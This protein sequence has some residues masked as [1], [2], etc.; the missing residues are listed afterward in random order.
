MNRRASRWAARRRATRRRRVAVALVVLASCAAAAAG[1]W[2]YGDTVPA[3]CRIDDLPEHPCNARQLLRPDGTPFDPTLAGG[4]VTG[5]DIIEWYGPD[6]V[7]PGPHTLTVRD[8][9]TGETDS[10]P[11]T[12]I[13]EAAS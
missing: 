13:P 9:E 5:A 10:W 6:T 4:K 1:C 11:W 7:G 8:P 2:L 12:V 3:Y